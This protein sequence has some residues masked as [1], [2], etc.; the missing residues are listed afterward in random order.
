MKNNRSFCP[1]NLMVEIV[2]DKWSLL[3]LSEIMFENKRH[4]RQ[5][6]QMEEKIASNILTDRLNMLEQQGMLT[7]KHDPDHKQGFIYGLTERSI[8][9]LPM[10][11]EGIRWS[12]AYE[13]VDLV[14][15]ASAV[16]L[17]QGGKDATSR[18]RND[19]LDMHHILPEKIN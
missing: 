13:P 15:Y 18:L 1:L 17:L 6:L 19:L 4:F 2:G 11:M 5:F 8:D 10:I 12:L 3:I 9:L 16:N 7:K 14:R